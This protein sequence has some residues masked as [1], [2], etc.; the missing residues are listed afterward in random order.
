MNRK[1][2]FPNYQFKL[3]DEGNK[4]LVFDEL[5]NKWVILTDEENVRQH[6]WKYLHKEHNYPKGLM[7]CEK[8]IIVNSLT[9]RFDLVI[10][11]KKGTPEILVECKA[12]SIELNQEVLNQALRYN[13]NLKA[14][15]IIISNGIEIKCCEISFK[16]GEL[17]YLE[18]LPN[19]D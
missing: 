8:K 19:I 14:K 12:P 11:N 13:I 2:A 7:V 16:K 6:L 1:L 9:K 18:S 17:I 10:Y 3:K 5:R 15:Y 4:T